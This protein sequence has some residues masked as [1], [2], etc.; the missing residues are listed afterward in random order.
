[1]RLVWLFG[2]MGFLL[3]NFTRLVD[4]WINRIALSFFIEIRLALRHF[5]MWS[6]LLS[7][8]LSMGYVR[9]LGLDYVLIICSHSR[10]DL[11]NGIFLVGIFVLIFLLQLMPTFLFFVI[12]I[13]ASIG[14]YGLQLIAFP[15]LGHQL[16]RNWSVSTLLQKLISS[17]LSLLVVFWV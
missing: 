3:I 15:I 16:G 14:N 7:W 10:N 4:R 6:N 17:H 11:V 13:L 9:P 2:Q 12:V 1:M 5:T 8:A